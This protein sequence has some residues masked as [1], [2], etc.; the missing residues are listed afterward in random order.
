ME[1]LFKPVSKGED[2]SVSECAAPQGAIL[3]TEVDP[4][5]PQ[6]GQGTHC[7]PIVVGGE[8]YTYARDPEY[9]KKITRGQNWMRSDRPDVPGSFTALL[10]AGAEGFHW[11]SLVTPEGKNY[12]F[13]NLDLNA[14][15][16]FTV[17]Q[18]Q[19]VFVADGKVDSLDTLK[20]Y[21]KTS[22][23]PTEYTCTEDALV[24]IFYK[25]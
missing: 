12:E 3:K 8:A 10:R 20:A 17:V 19:N 16:T 25:P 1:R 11:F 23:D 24:C 21:N 15:D 2:F 22:E 9:A 14:G 13:E 18:G 7:W 4:D 6:G 5:T